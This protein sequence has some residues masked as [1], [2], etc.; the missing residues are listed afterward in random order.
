[1]T[2]DRVWKMNCTCKIGWV[3]GTLCHICIPD[4]YQAR[5]LDFK[6]EE[7]L[8]LIYSCPISAQGRHPLSSALPTGLNI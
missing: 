1:M 4:E 6:F 2:M 8:V 3:A 5:K 7:A